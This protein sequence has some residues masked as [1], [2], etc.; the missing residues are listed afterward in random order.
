MKKLNP[1]LTLLS[2]ALLFVACN[3]TGVKSASK[4]RFN[5]EQATLPVEFILL[6]PS[7]WTIWNSN[8]KTT[9]KSKTSTSSGSR[10][11]C[12][13]RFCASWSKT[14]EK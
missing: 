11:P 4:S 5:P 9:L 10:R 1:G 14:Y 12:G 3:K 2:A 13:K 6:I 8:Q 7:H